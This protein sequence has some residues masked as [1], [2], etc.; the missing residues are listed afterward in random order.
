MARVGHTTNEKGYQVL[1]NHVRVI[2][3]DGIDIEDVRSIL[4]NLKLMRISGSNIAFGMGGGL[5]QKV[6]RDTFKFAMKCSAIELA[7]GEVRD[8]YKCPVG[9][10][11]KKSKRGILTAIQ[12]K[13]GV[14]HTIRK[15]ENQNRFG[16]KVMLHATHFSYAGEV[17]STVDD[18]ESIRHRAAIV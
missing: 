13:D 16:N 1:P 8:V 5:L 10:D 12:T 17:N 7:S 18:F 6:N 4:F 3:G 11:D 9:Q 2:Q 15:S 14:W